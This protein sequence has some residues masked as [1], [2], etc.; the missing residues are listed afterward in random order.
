MVQIHYRPLSLAEIIKK[1]LL[2]SG[3]TPHSHCGDASS[4][5]AR[6]I[7]KIVFILRHFLF[8]KSSGSM[9]YPIDLRGRS[10]YFGYRNKSKG[11]RTMLL[12]EL[13]KLES[14]YRTIGQALCLGALIFVALLEIIF[15]TTTSYIEKVTV[16]ANGDS[17]NE[18]VF[19]VNIIY[20]SVSMLIFGTL[21]MITLFKFQK[22]RNQIKVTI[23]NR[24][25]A[26]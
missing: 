11:N 6:S 8:Y 5:L 1:G 7:I 13:E 19:N 4:I 24:E 12:N 22:I 14:R 23:E 10:C 17:F 15:P 3:T 25:V 2:S 21:I 9:L 26:V 16:L 20:R 18:F